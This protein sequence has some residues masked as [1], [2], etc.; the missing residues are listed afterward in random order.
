MKMK[1][2]VDNPSNKQDMLTPMWRE[3]LQKIKDLVASG[4]PLS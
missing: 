2:K 4:Q 3:Q 1:E